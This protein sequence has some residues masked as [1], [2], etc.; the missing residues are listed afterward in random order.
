MKYSKEKILIHPPKI[1][2]F[3]FDTILCDGVLFLTIF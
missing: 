3:I 2:I 1:L